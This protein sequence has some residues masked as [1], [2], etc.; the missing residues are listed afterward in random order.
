MPVLGGLHS[1][2]KRRGPQHSVPSKEAP[3]H[4]SRVN[5]AMIVK[6]RA[7]SSYH[8]HILQRVTLK[9][10]SKRHSPLLRDSKALSEEP[11]KTAM[12]LIQL[13]PSACDSEPSPGRKFSSSRS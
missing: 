2:D 13:I 8:A 3:A 6:V 12:T 4:I 11:P 7:V 5:A 9:H 1:L 10:R